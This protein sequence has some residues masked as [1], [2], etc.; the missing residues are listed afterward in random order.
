VRPS[1]DRLLDMWIYVW[2][3][4][5]KCRERIFHGSCLHAKL[6]WCI[7]ILLFD[8]ARSSLGGSGSKSLVPF[9][10]IHKVRLMIEIKKII[11]L[12]V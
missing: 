7:A 1:I 9:N 10:E 6:M 8:D 3:Q 12:D 11:K 2:A 5:P 4:V